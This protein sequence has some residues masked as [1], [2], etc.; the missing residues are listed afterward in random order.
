ME[1]KSNLR[2]QVIQIPVPF[3]IKVQ[4]P[5]L[6]FIPMTLCVCVCVCV[7]VYP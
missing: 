2:R 4:D 3:N 5:L 7:C 6:H 1:G